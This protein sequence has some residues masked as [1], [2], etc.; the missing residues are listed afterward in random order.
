MSARRALLAVVLLGCAVAGS[1]LLPGFAGRG[2][3][4]LVAQQTQT[5]DTITPPAQTTSPASAPRAHPTSSDPAPHPAPT[6]R[7]GANGM[8]QDQ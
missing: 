3:A 4:R 8:F 5:P 1:W 2:V 6:P 7:C